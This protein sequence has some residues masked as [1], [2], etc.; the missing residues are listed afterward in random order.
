MSAQRDRGDDL[1]SGFTIVVTKSTVPVGT[2]EVERVLGGVR[3]PAKARRCRTSSPSF[4]T[5]HPDRIVSGSRF[6][7]QNSELL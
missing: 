6:G 7:D 4:Y 5:V 2:G 3:N 1:V